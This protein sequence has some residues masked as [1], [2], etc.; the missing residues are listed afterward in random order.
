MPKLLAEIA[1]D[2]RAD[3][4]TGALGKFPEHA[5][6]MMRV[7]EIWSHIDGDLTYLFSTFL[8]AD[9]QT[10][11]AVYEKINGAHQRRRAL[12]AAADAALPDWQRAVLRAVLNVIEPSRLVR[13][14]FAHGITGFSLDIPDVV[15]I[16]EPRVIT[17]ANVSRRQPTKRL[18]TGGRVFAPSQPDASG[19]SV[20][21]IE[22]ITD[23]G[24]EAHACATFVVQLAMAIGYRRNEQARRDLLRTPR[25]QT[26]LVRSIEKA[27]D[28]LKAQLLP[29]DDG[30]PAPGVWEAWDVKLGRDVSYW[31]DRDDII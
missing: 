4:A 17:A 8:A 20:W 23:A 29:P 21:T 6:A 26:A 11:T 3:F 30:P 7:I 14:E 24:R 5:A 2:A 15:L 12:L 31:E 16:A 10:A 28:F 27:D 18:A 19:I 22:A 1:P 25:I 13:N 9:I